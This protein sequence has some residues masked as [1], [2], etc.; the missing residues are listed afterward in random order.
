MTGVTFRTK[1][2]AIEVEEGLRPVK[3]PHP[4]CLYC[5]QPLDV[6]ALGHCLFDSTCFYP[7]DVATHLS[8]RCDC[9]TSCSMCEGTGIAPDSDLCPICAGHGRFL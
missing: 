2:Q 3:L 7:M 1:F 6:H 8:K 5:C 4:V 9:G